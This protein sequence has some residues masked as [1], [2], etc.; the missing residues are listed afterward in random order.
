MC[1]AD[2]EYTNMCRPHSWHYHVLP[3]ISVS[4]N[5]SASFPPIPPSV[6]WDSTGNS[7]ARGSGEDVGL[8]F[9]WRLTY[10]HCWYVELCEWAGLPHP[11]LT[12]CR[13]PG[14]AAHVHTL[15]KRL[16]KHRFVGI[17]EHKEVRACA[18]AAPLV[19]LWAQEWNVSNYLHGHRGWDACLWPCWPH[20]PALVCRVCACVCE[21]YVSDWCVSA[22]VTSAGN[23]STHSAALVAPRSGWASRGS[24]VSLLDS[25][26]SRLLPVAEESRPATASSVPESHHLAPP[27]ILKI[28]WSLKAVCPPCEPADMCP[29]WLLNQPEIEAGRSWTWRRQDR[30]GDAGGRGRKTKK[31]SVE[32]RKAKLYKNLQVIK[33]THYE[34]WLLASGGRL[35][36]I[37]RQH[38][39]IMS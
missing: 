33:L 38:N 11:R 14:D 5:M 7:R 8:A 15:K 10:A 39:V 31:G 12:C 35:S 26:R 19:F 4:P 27:T 16:L 18:R 9:K 28:R 34:R 17:Y 22:S 1:S 36:E 13:L 23:L 2:S 6:R 30:W 24:N 32:D 20:T 37:Y 29:Y 21:D 3:F 25:R